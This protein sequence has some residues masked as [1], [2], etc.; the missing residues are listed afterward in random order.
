MGNSLGTCSALVTA[1]GFCLNLSQIR[2]VYAAAPKLQPSMPLT[3]I[4]DCADE[5]NGFSA[6]HDLKINCDADALSCHDLVI[7]CPTTSDF[8]KIQLTCDNANSCKNVKIYT[9]HHLD[10]QC[11]HST[12]CN[13]V[14]VFC[15]NYVA[16]DW[17]TTYFTESYGNTNFAP[18]DNTKTCKLKCD[19]AA[20]SCQGVTFGCYESSQCDVEEKVDNAAD[21]VTIGCHNENSAACN[22]YCDTN[23]CK[24]PWFLFS[25]YCFLCIWTNI[26]ITAG[27]N[28]GLCRLNSPSP[29]HM[30]V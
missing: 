7:I 17:G 8:T 25:L 20:G 14:E 16:A 28:N 1:F 4:F 19:T 30:H 24:V 10:L 18:G 26:L 2:V 6:D 12:G 3:G 21:G 11:K 9:G 23:G 27:S 22:A 13:N 5:D 29:K 15:G